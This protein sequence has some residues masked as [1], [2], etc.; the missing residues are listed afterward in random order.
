MNQ[1]KGGIAQSM[2][3]PEAIVI[4][5][6]IL[7][8][9]AAT[10]ASN[11]TTQADLSLI[12]AQVGNVETTATGS[13]RDIK[14][15]QDKVASLERS[16]ASLQ[17]EFDSVSAANEEGLASNQAA[18]MVLYNILD[19]T[20]AETTGK[21]AYSAVGDVFLLWASHAGEGKEVVTQEVVFAVAA[22]GDV[23]LTT[24]WNDLSAVQKAFDSTPLPVTLLDM[25]TKSN[26]FMEL[27]AMKLVSISAP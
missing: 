16:L 25:N 26:A 15:E 27:L 23:E 21:L 10:K 5:S 2:T 13:T 11:A 22:T 4:Q 20:V 14:A 6:N 8:M 12:K 1:L 3:S 18:I 7:S 24:A 17:S 19:Q 9:L